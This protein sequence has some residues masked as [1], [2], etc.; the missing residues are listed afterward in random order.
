MIRSVPVQIVLNA[1]VGCDAADPSSWV[2][3]AIRAHCRAGIEVEVDLA[4]NG[5]GEGRIGYRDLSVPRLDGQEQD[6]LWLPLSAATTA[7]LRAVTG[8]EQV[9]GLPVPDWAAHA[10]RT[11]QDQVFSSP[12]QVPAAAQ[13]ASGIRRG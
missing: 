10:I 4:G 1:E 9:Q 11:G 5:A 6:W 13:V 2:A 3:E 12:A 7:V 8:R